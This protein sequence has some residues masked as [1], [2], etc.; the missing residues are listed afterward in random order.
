MIV[1][2]QP[3]TRNVKEY[4][5]TAKFFFAIVGYVALLTAATV[6]ES[7][8]VKLLAN[9]S[10]IG[11]FGLIFL[12]FLLMPSR[13]YLVGGLRTSLVIYYL[14]ML[15]S[16]VFSLQAQDAIDF[17]KIFLFPMFALFGCTFE[18]HRVNFWRRKIIKICFGLLIFLP[19]LAFAFQ[20]VMRG[21]SLSEGAEIGIFV[22]RNN[23][24][25]YAVT[26]MSLYIV[27]SGRSV[28]SA[29]PFLL[30]GV[31]FGTLGVLV[32]VLLGLFIAVGNWRTAKALLLGLIAGGL[33]IVVFPDMPIVQRLQPVFDSIRLL[34]SGKIDL[35]TVTFG[36]LVAQLQTT[37]LSFIFRLK[38]WRELLD[39]YAEGSALQWAFGL[40]VGSS[41]RLSEIGL[42][43]HNDYLRFFIECG[44]IALLGFASLLIALFAGIGRR[45]E[46]VPTIVVAI[47]FGSEN[48]I[49]NFLA[50]MIMFFCAGALATRMRL[51]ALEDRS[52]GGVKGAW[53]LPLPSAQG[54]SH[55][56]LSPELPQGLSS[57]GIK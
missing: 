28:S 11:I 50:M 17:L 44:W 39:L 8:A 30:V 5:P 22:N 43:P 45:W 29:L 54:A 7:D 48:L 26:L 55:G 9:M 51:L 27:L 20:I 32:A 46:A 38:H 12:E 18:L 40:G 57:G 19:L 47:Y 14:G 15:G 53:A 24:A 23:A 33:V 13:L 37:D 16:A 1:Y 21:A 56:G 41:V 6:T 36:D 35:R 42:V 2:S 52:R 25:L 49:N 31:M 34:A 10:A 3:L 4:N